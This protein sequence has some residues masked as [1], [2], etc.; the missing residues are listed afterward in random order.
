MPAH[1][2]IS[3]SAT[4]AQ[5]FVLKLAD[6]L[7]A[8]P[9]AFP[10]WIFPRD[11]HAGD[12]D[13]QID[14]AIRTCDSL[15]FV[16]TRDSVRDNSNC[17]IEWTAALKYKKPILLVRL[18]P[19]DAPFRLGSRQWIDFT[20]D[21]NAA[22][23]KLRKDLQ[24]L[25]SPQGELQALRYRL[26]DAER[27]LDRATDA[28]ERTRIQ[29]DIEQLRAQIAEQERIVAD[30]DAAARATDARIR[31]G[32]ERE[33]EPA[34]RVRTTTKFINPPPLTAPRYFQDR[35]TENRFIADFLRDESKRLLTIS[36]RAGIGK[37]AM[38]CRILK[39]LESGHLPDDLGELR[40]DGIVYLSAVGTRTIRFAHLFEDLGKLLPAETARELDA[41][42]RDP[43]ISTR[44]KMIA[45]LEKFPRGLVL[46][47]LDNFESVMDVS[48]CCLT[49]AELDEALRA[50]L[51]APHHAV[52][53]IL[54]TRI[55]PRD[56]QLYHS[57]AQAYLPVDTGLESSYAKQL[58]RALDADGKVGLRDADDARLDLA[59]TRTRGFPRALEA[60][61][62]I[63][64][65]DRYTMLDEIL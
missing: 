33:R 7:Q 21:Y 14:D 45:L 6:D 23:A 34:E 47:L 55:P 61:Y 19:V 42:Y 64:A 17:K 52:K 49:D 16:M 29:A 62:G 18:H 32:I 28:T 27:D 10:V 63:L 20:R 46:V 48:E 35:H 60:L 1:H 40:V 57:G 37:T 54:T 59:V 44:Q 11:L 4:D 15:I 3:Y 51:D 36:G 8:G 53:I 25:H 39:S 30:P 38:I 58:L 65:A 43:K 26:L 13:A 50:L 9:P 5:D 41:L 22:L 2:F 31:A 12:W 56:L 24:Y